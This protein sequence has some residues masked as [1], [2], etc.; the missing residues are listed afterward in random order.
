MNVVAVIVHWGAV[1]PTIRLTQQL[2]EISLFSGVIVVANDGK[3]R[4]SSFGSKF[5]WLVPDSNRG[6]GGGFMAGYEV[7]PDADVYLLLNN[8]VQLT[9]TTVRECL[10]VFSDPQVGIVGPTQVNVDGIHTGCGRM[11]PLV[12]IPKKR[13]VPSTQNDEVDWING[14]MMFIKGDS[15]RRVPMPVKYFLGYEDTDYCYRVRAAGWRIVVSPA[16]A[17]HSGGG[18]LP[19]A[20]FSYYLT[21]NRIWFARTHRSASTVAL[22]T[23]WSALAVAP[24]A[25]LKETVSGQSRGLFRMIVHGIRDGVAEQPKLD[26]LMSNEPR[27]SLWGSWAGAG[28]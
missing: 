13:R 20:G 24:R 8:D 25:A 11:T 18:T 28:T 16:Q 4:P 26:E 19:K 22:V 9:E 17:W 5:T 21:R 1:E 23:A 27:P 12:T 2:D 7:A 14:A 10:E 3:P 15:L 6:F